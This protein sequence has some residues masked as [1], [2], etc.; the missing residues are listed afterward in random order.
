MRLLSSNHHIEQQKIG[1]R[2]RFEARYSSSAFLCGC[3]VTCFGTSLVAPV[4]YVNVS[5]LRLR[6]AMSE[7]GCPARLVIH[8]SRM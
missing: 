5:F 3:V 7:R 6:C 1:A 8:A 2:R 4:L